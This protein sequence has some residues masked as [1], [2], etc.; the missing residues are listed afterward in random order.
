MKRF[1]SR[2]SN[3]LFQLIF[4]LLTT[5]RSR[6]DIVLTIYI[7]LIFKELIWYISDDFWHHTLSGLLGPFYQFLAIKSVK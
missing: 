7:K 2:K 3:Y 4:E 1:I 6:K 5:H